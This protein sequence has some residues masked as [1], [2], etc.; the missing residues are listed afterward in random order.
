L[1]MR[2]ISDTKLVVAV[3]VMWGILQP[4]PGEMWP[5][6][7]RSSGYYFPVLVTSRQENFE[8]FVLAER[9]VQLA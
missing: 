9:T 3:M 2:S 8:L 1:A 5:S 6:K 4:R 7:S